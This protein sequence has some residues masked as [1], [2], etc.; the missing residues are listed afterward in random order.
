MFLQTFDSA[1][2]DFL[3]IDKCPL[4]Q[5]PT[6][7]NTLNQLLGMKLFQSMVL[8]W[9]ADVALTNKHH[10]KFFSIFFVDVNVTE[11]PQGLLSPDFPPK[12]M[13]IEFVRTNVS[14]LSD[15]LDSHW[16]KGMFLIM[17]KCQFQEVLSVISHME[18]RYLSLAENNISVV[19]REFLNTMSPVMLFFSP[20]IRSTCCLAA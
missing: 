20:G 18:P 8:N 7:F 19:L 16:P 13:D 12:F 3:V 2:I 5:F 4:F 17:E 1:R 10:P 11:L 15:N 14:R 6:R 9:D